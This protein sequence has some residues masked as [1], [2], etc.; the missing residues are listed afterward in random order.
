MVLVS[1][2]LVSVV[3][4]FGLLG[5]VW[6]SLVVLFVV[7]FVFGLLFIIVWVRDSWNSDRVSCWMLFSL[8]CK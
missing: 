5:R 8:C 7:L 1:S 2:V 4:F 3:W 6:V